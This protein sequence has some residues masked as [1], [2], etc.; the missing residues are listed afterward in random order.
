M[1]GLV[2]GFVGAGQK[3]LRMVVAVGNPAG[4]TKTGGEADRFA[5]KVHLDFFDVGTKRLRQC[6]TLFQGAVNEQN[7]ELFAAKSGQHIASAMN[8]GPHEVGQHAQAG[9]TGQMAMAVIDP[10][11]MVDIKHDERKRTL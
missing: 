3:V 2:Q 8:P 11:E 5:L 10:L 4:H 9:I 6:H 1:L 7:H